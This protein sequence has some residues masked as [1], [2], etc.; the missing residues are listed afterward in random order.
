MSERD[1]LQITDYSW[2][3]TNENYDPDRANNGGGYSQPDYSISFSDGVSVKISDTSCGE[4][5]SRISADIYENGERVGG[6]TYGSMY[7]FENNTHMINSDIDEKYKDHLEL[8]ADVTGYEIPTEHDIE[9]FFNDL[10]QDDN[11]IEMTDADEVEAPGLSDAVEADNQF[12]SDWF[13]GKG[14][15]LTDDEIEMLAP[16]EDDE[17]SVD[18]GNED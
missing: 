11:D 17:D 6:A 12:D 7:E 13:E 4:F 1:N 16:E 9:D 3:E 5:G 15:D 18:C 8:V 10:E 14:A 2:V